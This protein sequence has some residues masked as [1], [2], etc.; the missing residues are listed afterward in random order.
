[1]NTMVVRREGALRW[2]T[3]SPTVVS[4]VAR[5]QRDL[6]LVA[7][8][9][10]VLGTTVSVLGIAA[11]GT[12]EPAKVRA[13]VLVTAVLL[14]A[15]LALIARGVRIRLP[16]A[17]WWVLATDVGLAIALNF[18]ACTLV[19]TGTLFL[20]YGNP[21]SVYA[22]T[23]VALW[24]GATRPRVGLALTVLMALPT[25]VAMAA[26]NG[27]APA[28]LDWAR[29]VVRGLWF[30]TAFA[31]ARLLLT[32]LA[33]G[34]HVLSVESERAGRAARRAETL[35][36]LHDGVLHALAWIAKRCENRRSD[37]DATL[38]Q[39]GAEARRRAAQVSA[40]LRTDQREWS[41]PH[42]ELE[43]V[44]AEAAGR[45]VLDSQLVAIGPEPRLEPAAARA[46]VG[47]VGEA[48]RNAERHAGTARV[49][50]YVDRVEGN[51]RAIV[52]DDGC[53]FDP[54]RL[55]AGT[56]GLRH[57][58]KERLAQV[59]GDATLTT[60]PGAGTTWQLRVPVATAGLPAEPRDIA[61]LLERAVM[62]LALVALSYRGLGL[63]ISMA[64]LVASQSFGPIPLVPLL[65][66]MA[67]VLSGH[68]VLVLVGFGGRL[69]R[70][71]PWLVACDLMLAGGLALWAA[72]VVPAGTVFLDYRDAFGLYL[73]GTLA[74]WTGCIGLRLALPLLVL[75]ALPL[76]IAMSIVNQLPLAAVPWAKVTS[77]AFWLVPVFALALVVRW[78]A[79]R[80]ARVL[81][82]ERRRAGEQDE[83]AEALRALHERGLDTLVAITRRSAKAGAD[84]R[85]TLTEIGTRCRHQSA[86][87]SAALQSAQSGWDGLFADLTVLAAEMGT[88][89]PVSVQFV[90]SGQE[91]LL[92]ASIR[93][94]LVAAVGDAV[95]ALAQGGGSRTLA[96]S[97]DAG[98]DGLRVVVC[99]PCPGSLTA[100]E[101]VAL[102]VR[103]AAHVADVGGW[104][105][106]S[107]CEFEGSTWKVGLPSGT[108]PRRAA[109]GGF[110]PFLRR[111]GRGR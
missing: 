13:L 100:E 107:G 16:A 28:R 93:Q 55:P 72:K 21:F 49:N 60:A 2:S 29:F 61:P 83:R 63:A 73:Q 33:H 82:H 111:L 51:L 52:R 18:W 20:D 95:S 44:V 58:I 85:Q 105:E 39:V 91:P 88:G 86:Q 70:A 109:N 22:V 3:Q 101:A 110:P 7:L 92:E 80:G 68:V 75:I 106:V 57:S 98:D 5:T 32:A 67:A 36:A 84:A 15:H 56:Y 37:P 62:W 74:L 24:S 40:L 45:G 11:S 104:V 77:R 99:D 48:L 30:V 34:A 94:A 53:G 12:L 79:R 76:Q 43:Q 31:V 25:Q 4:L 9:Y 27:I 26:L 97:V 102:E 103:T 96:L 1:M 42:A 81:A 50:L 23:T 17:R 38:A 47:A 64:G 14:G 19:P 71:R 6:V 78:V 54:T 41:G 46:L 8:G 69:P 89:G 59:G 65:L 90:A 35:R 10:R 108:R 87:V 66:V